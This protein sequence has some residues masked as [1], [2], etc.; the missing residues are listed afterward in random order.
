MHRGVLGQGHFMLRE[1]Q[2]SARGRCS[3]NLQQ[4]R[5][6]SATKYAD[7]VDKISVQQQEEQKLQKPAAKPKPLRQGFDYTVLVACITE[8]QQNW[9]PAKVDQV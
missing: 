2:N 3:A 4:L 6:R 9:L 5:A 8:L 1:D 7:L